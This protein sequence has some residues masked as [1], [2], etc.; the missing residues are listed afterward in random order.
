MSANSRFI[1]GLAY[2]TLFAI[3]FL[4]FWEATVKGKML[5]TPGSGGSDITH[6]NYPSR[7][8]LGETLR[9]EG[10]IPLWCPYIMNGFPIHAEGQGGFLYPLNYILFRFLPSPSA[11][12]YSV[13]LTFFIAGSGTMAFGRL[14]GLGVLGS[15]TSGIVFMLSGFFVAHVR[16]L[17]MIQAASLF[18]WALYFS[19]KFLRT[20]KLFFAACS[21]V[22]LG[23][24]ILAG[25]PQ[26]FYY[27]AGV[28]ALYILLRGYWRDENR[29]SFRK[30]LLGMALALLVALGVGAAQ[31]FPTY[32][33]FQNS[34]RA[35]GVPHLW[36]AGWAYSFRDLLTFLSPFQMGRPSQGYFLEISDLFWEN[37]FY[38]GTLS[39]WLSCFVV[40]LQFKR[41]IH[42]RALVVIGAISVAVALSGAFGMEGLLRDALP[43]FDFFRVHQRIL[44]IFAFSMTL[45]AGFGVHFVLEKLGKV[46][47]FLLLAIVSVDLFITGYKENAYADTSAWF[48][49]PP[50]LHIVR[51]KPGRILSDS[52]DAYMKAFKV[53][54]GW[55][56]GT[57]A[58]SAIRRSLA[59]NSNIEWEV[60]AVHGHG[61]LFLKRFDNLWKILSANLWSQEERNESVIT[62]LGRRLL[63]LQNTQYLLTFFTVKTPGF[64]PLFESRY[65]EGLPTF[66]MYGNMNSLPRAIVVSKARYAKTGEEALRILL[67]NDF[68]PSRSVLLE[69]KESFS[70]GMAGK[71]RAEI[72]EETPHHLTLSVSSEKEGFL[73]LSDTFY[74]GWK[75]ALDGKETPILRANY[76][77]RAI[78][79]PAGNHE[80]VFQYEPFSYKLGCW[81]SSLT[82]AGIVVFLGTWLFRIRK[83]RLD[84][85]GWWG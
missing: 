7:A 82:L 18:P 79:L 28:L 29:V 81:V 73:V 41:N 22:A 50:F 40:F 1:W 63:N 17:N 66:R 10:H 76:A 39:L 26:I 67:K 25:F 61:A 34:I 24:S 78:R 44:F 52:Y 8:Y 33:L 80:V 14:L 36:K 49:H 58:Y 70:P 30:S 23:L 54:S 5:A 48:Q 27:S 13:V 64:V 65:T 4:F 2:L 35:G 83:E 32:E 43:G 85:C 16:H 20:G 57:N 68:D 15:L 59:P 12:T 47:A 56:L 71:W 45:L 37:F 3:A 55:R 6:L 31:W 11:F 46:A 84:I 72:K 75:A 21:G 53:S 60:P 9:R 42:V 69:E 51:A 62:P 74:P 38:T 77:F 19:E